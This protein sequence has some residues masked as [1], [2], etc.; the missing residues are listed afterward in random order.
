MQ[1]MVKPAAG[2]AHRQ[3]G[4]IYCPR[5]GLRL[6]LASR[7]TGEYTVGY[8]I[9]TWAERCTQFELDS[10]LACLMSTAGDRNIC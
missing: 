10:P 5:C 6:Q 9:E 4:E 7:S 2:E 3:Q 8:S 1:E